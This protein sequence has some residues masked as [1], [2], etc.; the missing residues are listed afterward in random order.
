MGLSAQHARVSPETTTTR[1]V[2]SRSLSKPAVISGFAALGS[3]LSRTGRS[4]SEL[5]NI[6][7]LVELHREGGSVWEIA[8]RSDSF[9]LT[10]RDLPLAKEPITATEPQSQ[11][12]H[13]FLAGAWET[14]ARRSSDPKPRQRQGA[15]G[16]RG[17]RPAGHPAQREPTATLGKI[18]RR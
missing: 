8:G 15:K 5:R 7:E 16:G 17:S 3:A 14:I 18:T 2:R 1:S 11:R 10:R 13:D 12:V 4:D 9:V 6:A